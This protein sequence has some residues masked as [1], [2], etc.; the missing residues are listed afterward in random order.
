MCF[1]QACIALLVACALAAPAP[2][3]GR[4]DKRSGWHGEL[5]PGAYSLPA[6]LVSHA[7]LYS[8][9]AAII[10]EPAIV[11][12]K[13]IV[14]VPEVSRITCE[15]GFLPVIC[16]P[17]TS[18]SHSPNGRVF[19]QSYRVKLNF[20]RSDCLSDPRMQWL[21]HTTVRYP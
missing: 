13:K 20:R 1:I 15:G 10:H 16:L 4:R 7:A 14:S 21:E 6:P 11:S 2:E 12:V 5:A 17:N 3:H 9:P 8:A 19:F 18:G